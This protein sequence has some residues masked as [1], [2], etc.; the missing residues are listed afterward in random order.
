MKLKPMNCPNCGSNS[1]DVE[2]RICT[3]C[4]TKFKS[5]DED[6]GVIRIEQFTSPTRVLCMES[7]IS[8]E[9][10]ESAPD[11]VIPYA[12]REIAERLADKLLQGDLVE[13]RSEMD[14]TR[15]QQ[16]ISARLRVL[17]PRYRF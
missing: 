11:H 10:V 8:N 6:V 3:Y 17:D 14:M 1:V 2:N 16:I 7:H 4:G 12:K 9:F 13:F 15:C 5:A